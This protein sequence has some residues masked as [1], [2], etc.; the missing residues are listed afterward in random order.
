MN[1]ELLALVEPIVHSFDYELWGLEYL[2]QGRYSTLKIYIESEKGV[3]VDDCAKI[4]RQVGS[5]MDVE[6][7]ISSKYTLEVSSPGVDRRLFALAQYDKYK[8]AKIKI[9]LRT[10]YEGKRKFKGLLC[11]VEEGDIVLRVGD[12]EY[13]FPFEDID[14]ANVVPVFD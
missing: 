7:L 1:E 10:A 8:G 12:E 5:V 4:S 14:R 3:D 13:L 6:D 11:G 2:T 9:N